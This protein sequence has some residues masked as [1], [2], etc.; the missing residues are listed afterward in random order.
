MEIHR[1][2]LYIRDKIGTKRSGDKLCFNYKIQFMHR[3]CKII[4]GVLVLNHFPERIVGE[5]M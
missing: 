5:V 4:T 3:Q 1:L 2:N